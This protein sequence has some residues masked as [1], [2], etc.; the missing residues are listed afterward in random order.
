MR[1]QSILLS[2]AAIGALIAVSCGMPAAAAAKHHKAAATASKS[3]KLEELEAKVQFLTDRLDEQ[4]AVTRDQ[5]AQLKA[6]QDAAAQAKAQAAAAVATANADDA[7]I[8]TIPATVKTAVAATAP[9]SGWADSTSVNGRMYYNMSNVTIKKDGV[10]QSPSGFGFDVKRFYVGVDHKFDNTYSANVTTDFTYN[11]TAGQTIVYIKKAYLQAHYSDA[12]TLVAGAADMPWIPFME[13]LYGNRYVEQ[14]LVD[15]L[16]YGTSSD[17][18]LQATGKFGDKGMF[19]YKVA[20][21]DGAGYKVPNRSKSVDVEGRFNVN[22]DKLTLAVGGYDGKLGKDNVVAPGAT[23]L[24]FHT[25]SR[26]NAAAA[27]VDP[28]FR[29]GGEYFQATDWNNVTSTTADKSQG[30]SVFGTVYFA[31]KFSLFGN[32]QYVQPSQTIKPSTKDNYYNIGVS[33]SPAKIV[34]F[35]LVYKH[36]RVD[37]GTIATGNATLGAA[38]NHNGQ[39][40]EVGVFSQLR[41]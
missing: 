2:G 37:N 5:M 39:Y 35:A 15:R 1:T 41:W 12:F 6:A 3:S 32:Y 23:P 19:N 40:D 13:D 25:A 28:M 24:T 31:P 27:W 33:Y 9:K 10:N 18:G 34:D 8:K 17:W 26:L 20:V 7:T 14:T 16:K 29:V 36:D 38:G 21:V 11:S 30:Y 22:I 4:A